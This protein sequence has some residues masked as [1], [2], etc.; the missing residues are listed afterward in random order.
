MVNL[1]NVMKEYEGSVCA[2]GDFNT[3]PGYIADAIN[4]ALLM[5]LNLFQRM[6]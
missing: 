4:S 2:M 3:I 1:Q 6:N 5:N